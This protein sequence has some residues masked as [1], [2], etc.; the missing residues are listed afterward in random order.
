MQDPKHLEIYDIDIMNENIKNYYTRTFNHGVVI[1]GDYVIYCSRH[2]SMSGNE[3]EFIPGNYKTCQVKESYKGSAFWWNKWNVD[4]VYN[5]TV[6]KCCRK[7][8]LNCCRTADVDFKDEI[9]VDIKISEEH[10]KAYRGLEKMITAYKPCLSAEDL[11]DCGGIDK[12]PKN[13]LTEFGDTRIYLYGDNKL[14]MHFSNISYIIIFEINIIDGGDKIKLELTVIF[15][16]GITSVPAGINQ[17]IIC[18]DNLEALYVKG[19]DLESKPVKIY[20]YDWYYQFFSRGV[21]HHGVEMRTIED[22][23]MGLMYHGQHILQFDP[24]YKFHGRGSY[25]EQKT[26]L[27]GTEKI[28][29]DTYPND[30][31]TSEINKK[32]VPNMSFSTPSIKITK[33][34]KD[35]YLGVGHSK[36]INDNSVRY[37][38]GSTI[39]RFRTRLHEDMGRLFGNR[40]KAHYGTNILRGP[41]RYNQR[42]K[43]EELPA[44]CKGYIYFMYFTL[45]Q[46]DERRFDDPNMKMFI[47]DS[48][49]P[50]NF[51]KEDDDKQ[52]FFSLF[53]PVGIAQL[54]ENVLITGGDGDYYNLNIELDL[55]FVIKSCVHDIQKMDFST[56]QYLLMGSYNGH[57]AISPKLIDILR[58]LNV[59]S[60][61]SKTEADAPVPE[62]EAAEAAPVMS[63]ADGLKIEDFIGKI[64]RKTYQLIK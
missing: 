27:K 9:E 16:N 13:V 39:E 20:A 1:Y 6:I 14:V 54:D 60:K 19:W 52:Y 58:N 10:K 42:Q 49:M 53:F 59:E 11:V 56:Y 36:I 38:E 5:N 34:G 57:K 18:I 2:N 64:K 47:S 63:E 35:Y 50:L 44:D 4:G 48:F 31:V 25:I 43:I 3:D 37:K 26:E 24:D 45:L 8:K 29:I 32:I 33:G 40:Y 21:N 23:H 17:S 41:N 12:G 61:K 55:D 15:A 28:T 51:N 7:D 30:D 62:A 22:G 46:M